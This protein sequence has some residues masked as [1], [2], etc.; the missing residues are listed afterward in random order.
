LIEESF[1]ILKFQLAWAKNPAH[2]KSAQVAHF[3]LCLM[4]FCCLEAESAATG[5]S[6]YSIGRCL[7]PD[8]VSKHSHLIQ[9][10]TLAA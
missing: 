8:A 2:S 5:L 3:H 4:A 9:Y 7:F 1:K 6:P 10:F